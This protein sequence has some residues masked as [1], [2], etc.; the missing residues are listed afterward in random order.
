MKSLLL[1]IL[2]A[3]FFISLSSTSI[4][5]DASLTGHYN[6]GPVI[7]NG[8]HSIHVII[9]NQGS[10]PITSMTIGY[11]INSITQMPYVWTGNLLPDDT[12]SA[13]LGT[14]ISATGNYDITTYCT[15]PGDTIQTNDTMHIFSQSK[16]LHDAK[17]DLIFGLPDTVN[18]NQS[19]SVS[20]RIINDGLA[21]LYS[22]PIS[23]KQ[24][25]NNPH[26][27]MLYATLQPNDTAQY[28]FS[29]L[30]YP[31]LGN[32]Y[33]KAYSSFNNDVNFSNDT[34]YHTLV[35]E[36]KVDV[37]ILSIISPTNTINNLQNQSITVVVKNYGT[38][39]VPFIP[40]MYEVN[41]NSPIL[42][43]IYPFPFLA[44]S[45]S[46]T[47]TFNS[48]FSPIFGSNSIKVYTSLLGDQ[49]N[50]NDTLYKTVNVVFGASIGGTVFASQMPIDSG[51]A[52]LYALDT[53]TNNI[54]L[55]DSAIID[56][57]GYYDFHNTIPGIYIVK[58]M[59]TSNS[60][61][62]GQY[63][64]TY[65][66][67]SMSW[68][69]A[70]QINLSTTNYWGADI[71][72]IPVVPLIPGN[73][74]ISGTIYNNVKKGTPL[75]GIEIV[76]LDNNNNIVGIDY[77]D[78]NGQYSFLMIPF[79]TYTIYPEVTGLISF[80]TTVTLDS[81]NQDITGLDVSIDGKTATVGIQEEIIRHALNS[82]NIYP[83]PTTENI[84]IKLFLNKPSEIQVNVFNQSGQLITT[85]LSDELAGEQIIKL[86]I[87]NL[88]KG[89]YF[90][91]VISASQTINK[92]LIKL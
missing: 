31:N 2:F 3:T 52:F 60:T 22:I 77:S 81:A 38:N 47:F 42:D 10:N 13:V 36:Q 55:I 15:A 56:T 92:K 48:T 41:L 76:M 75:E 50:T 29:S 9:K 12:T 32:N 83:N 80:S 39:S 54:T 44:P 62:Y 74:S 43:T 72:L 66:G 45:D 14:F 70:I 11:E 67:D 5:Q 23:Y 34:A 28:T 16:P 64:S 17:V 90:L 19:Q 68:N 63:I 24:N 26:N 25:N 37:S 82:V 53:L 86:N 73:G 1:K 51:L 84:N 18:N 78:I 87:S 35:N 46:I 59:L 79:D 21:A 85:N 89:V 57:L 7:L 8:N 49:I 20:I 69:K 88:P 65:Y 61:S 30:L 27:E 6:P 71:N 91:Q 4:A 33:I 58:A 40:I